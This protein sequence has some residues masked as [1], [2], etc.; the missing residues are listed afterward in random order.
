[1]LS[2]STPERCNDLKF[3]A[4]V[5]SDFCQAYIGVQFLYFDLVC[6]CNCEGLGW[7]GGGYGLGQGEEV[8]MEWGREYRNCSI[9]ED[10]SYCS[11][12]I[13]NCVIHYL[14]NSRYIIQA[15]QKVVLLSAFN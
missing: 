13:G 5:I 1:M 4:A 9:F 15:V 10:H 7:R 3:E 6:L 14:D 8:D 12:V 2:H 11:Q